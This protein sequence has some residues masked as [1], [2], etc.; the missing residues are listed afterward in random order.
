MKPKPEGRR[1]GFFLFLPMNLETDKSLACF[2]ILDQVFPMGGDGLRESPEKCM[3]CDHKTAC[4]RAAASG[5]PGLDLKKE[6]VDRAYESGNMGFLKRWSRKKRIARQ[7]EKQA[8][9]EE[10]D[11]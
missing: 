11:T 8:I 7:Q 10:P 9:K 5:G 3:A 6:Q 4:L 2:G 1:K